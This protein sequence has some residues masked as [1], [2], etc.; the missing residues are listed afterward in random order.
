MALIKVGV[1][2]ILLRAVLV[3]LAPSFKLQKMHLLTADKLEENVLWT[4]KLEQGG[5]L[6]DV[7]TI[8]PETKLKQ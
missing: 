2:Q 7:I 4:T 3:L 5:V 6:I 1:R 8:N